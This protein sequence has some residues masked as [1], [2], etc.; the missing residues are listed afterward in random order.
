KASRSSETTVGGK[1]PRLFVKL[2]WAWRLPWKDRFNSGAQHRPNPGHSTMTSP[3][4]R[5]ACRACSENSLLPLR[6]ANFPS[7]PNGTCYFYSGSMKP[8]PA[9]TCTRA[10][11]EA[12]VHLQ[13]CPAERDY[14]VIL[15][16]ADPMGLREDEKPIHKAV[17]RFLIEHDKPSL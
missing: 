11:L 14:N 3:G 1:T 8:T 17:N 4:R 10:W 15:E 7:L 6:R 2:R 12:V 9:A 5:K 13:D 16:I